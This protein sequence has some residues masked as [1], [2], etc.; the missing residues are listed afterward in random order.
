V[1]GR[2]RAV[3]LVEQRDGDP[4]ASAAQP[5][6][7]PMKTP[8]PRLGGSAASALRSRVESRIVRAVGSM[9]AV[10]TMRRAAPAARDANPR[11]PVHEPAAPRLRVATYNI[12]KGVLRDFIGL[13]RVARIH[14]LRTRLHEL[15]SD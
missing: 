5:C 6:G 3:F 10:G 9:R 12:H 7:G 4:P 11:A 15:G 13:R 2:R 14:E 1:G 8:V